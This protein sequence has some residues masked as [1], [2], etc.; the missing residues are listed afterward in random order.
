MTFKL[1]LILLISVIFL[2]GCVSTWFGTGRVID[3]SY[4][5]GHLAYYGKNMWMNEPAC[6]RL[7][8]RE[9]NGDDHS[10]CVKRSV[11]DAAEVGKTIT[12]NEQTQR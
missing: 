10:G 5:P 9:Y 2:T 11:W 7:M 1:L 4:T 8:V 3:K 6:Y 12:L